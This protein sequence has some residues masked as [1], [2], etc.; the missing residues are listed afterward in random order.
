MNLQPTLSSELILLRPLEES[1]FESLYAIA[2]DPLV[3]EQHPAKNRSERDVFK[4]LFQEF[5]ESRGTLLILD[6]KTNEIIGSSRYYDYRPEEKSVAIGFTMLARKYWGGTYNRVLK[7]MMLEHA[8]KSMDRVIFHVGAENIR[9][10]KALH[11]IGAMEFERSVRVL[12]DGRQ[13]PQVHYRILRTE[14][15]I[16]KMGP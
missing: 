5:I 11:K 13:I 3:W 14:F 2:S 6:R 9:S 1:D 16:R 12:P 7:S 10:Q 8:F 4:K 15:R